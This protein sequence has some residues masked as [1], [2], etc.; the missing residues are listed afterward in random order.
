MSSESVSFSVCLC[1][2]YRAVNYT[3]LL[4]DIFLL[5]GVYTFSCTPHCLRPWPNLYLSSTVM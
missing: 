3:F 4:I 1:N 2:I 5:I